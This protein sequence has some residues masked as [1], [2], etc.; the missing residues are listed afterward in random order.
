MVFYKSRAGRVLG[1]FLAEAQSDTEFAELFRERFLKP[2][3]EVTGAIFDRGV[4]RGEID[5]KLDRE[6]VIDMIYGPVVYRMLVGHAPLTARWQIVSC[7]LCLAGWRWPES[8]ERLLEN[9][10]SHVGKERAPGKND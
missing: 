6:L 10:T 2:R 7:R 3:R 9:T 8:E 1:Q 4:R 5:P